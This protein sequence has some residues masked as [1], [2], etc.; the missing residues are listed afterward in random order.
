MNL[1][2]LRPWHLYLTVGLALVL[3]FVWVLRHKSPT[4]RAIEQRLAAM[5]AAGEPV[6]TREVAARFPDP[7]PHLDADKLLKEAM[8]FAQ[9]NFPQST[10]LPVISSPIPKVDKAIAVELMPE[11][12]RVYEESQPLATLWK[13]LPTEA[14]FPVRHNG[15]IP[16]FNFYRI[17]TTVQLLALRAL[18]EIETGRT[19][20]LAVTLERSFRLPAMLPDGS[21]LV[22]H[23]M[24]VACLDLAGTNLERALNRASLSQEQLAAI[25]TAIPEF[26][27]FIRTMRA[28]RA[29]AVQ[30]FSELRAG[31]PLSDYT[32][33]GTPVPIWQ[34]WLARFR[35]PPAYTDADF[36]LYL[37]ESEAFLKLTNLPAV[38]LYHATSVIVSNYAARTTSEGARLVGVNYRKAME[39]R[40]A[41]EA[42]MAGLKAALAVEQQR[43]ATGRLPDELTM[44]IPLDPYSAQPLRWERLERGYQFRSVGPDGVLATNGNG[45]DIIVQVLR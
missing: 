41:V 12:A 34:R 39:R 11:L 3:A 9:A 25:Y 44:P 32:N 13:E 23:M 20:E 37:E 21:S 40:F 26:P 5:R 28:E 4:E 10:R 6:H 35:H 36:L 8:D 45:D 15:E 17:R 31:R 19:R 42:R 2:A 22:T 18:F 16:T 30:V 1:R 7:P 27:D 33:P 14:R 29:F 24:A 43:L 38:P